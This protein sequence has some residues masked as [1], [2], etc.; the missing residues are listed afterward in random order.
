MREEGVRIYGTLRVHI[1]GTLKV[2]N[3]FPGKIC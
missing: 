1:Y 3:N 2:H